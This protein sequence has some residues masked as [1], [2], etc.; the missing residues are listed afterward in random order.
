LALD[1]EYFTPSEPKLN[2][3]CSE[4][5]GF[6]MGRLG[7]YIVLSWPQWAHRW[8]NGT[9]AHLECGRWCVRDKVGSN[10]RL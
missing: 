4:E 5:S 1:A 3:R 9:R 10:Q 6:Q 2:V 8:C 7:N